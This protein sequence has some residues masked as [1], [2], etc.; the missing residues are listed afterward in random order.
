MTA[1]FIIEHSSRNKMTQQP[2]CLVN[3]SKAEEVPPSDS[4]S[5]DDNKK[6]KDKPPSQPL[7][8]SGVLEIK[9][10]MGIL[11]G[12][13]Q[14][15]SSLPVIETP[16]STSFNSANRKR[17]KIRMVSEPKADNREERTKSTIIVNKQ[18]ICEES[19][20]PKARPASFVELGD[21]DDDSADDE[22]FFQSHKKSSKQR[23]RR[24]HSSH[25]PTGEHRQRNLDTSENAHIHGISFRRHISHSHSP[26]REFRRK[27]SHDSILQKKTNS[28]IS[29]K[30]AEA[31]QKLNLLR[32]QRSELLG[33]GAR[34]EKKIDLLGSNSEHNPRRVLSDHDNSDNKDT[35]AKKTEAMQRLRELRKQRSVI[36]GRPGDKAKTGDQLVG[37]SEHDGESRHSGSLSP[38]PETQQ[39]RRSA[40]TELRRLQRQNSREKNIGKCDDQLSHSTRS[41]DRRRHSSHSPTRQF[42]T[43]SRSKNFRELLRQ[44][45]Q[46]NLLGRGRGRGREDN[47]QPTRRYSSHSPV[48]TLRSRNGCNTSSLDT[49]NTSG[50]TNSC[51][52]TSTIQSQSAEKVKSFRELQSQSSQKNLMRLSIRRQSSREKLVSNN[53]R[54]DSLI[55]EV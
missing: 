12:V 32:K 39:R 24:R 54:D 52:D 5:D 47:E 17:F 26:V 42:R 25:S 46:E 50:S 34:K 2:E 22:E 18:V 6:H 36:L 9:M 38:N 14:R 20:H 41:R 51:L 8:R 11:E 43:S 3:P 7:R 10:G 37:N 33:K 23:R 29:D 49:S 19:T 44:S 27:N 55:Q 15:A 45:S 1:A 40:S 4:S 16:K 35:A 48:N 13:E 31:L 28:P 53:F 30:K 21:D